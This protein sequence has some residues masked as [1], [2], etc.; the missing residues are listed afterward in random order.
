MMCQAKPFLFL[1]FF[2]YKT[3]IPMKILCILWRGSQNEDP[4][5]LTARS[6]GISGDSSLSRDGS[7]L[8]EME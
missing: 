4:H 7:G 8:E 5:S 3:A 2:K 1:S 6:S